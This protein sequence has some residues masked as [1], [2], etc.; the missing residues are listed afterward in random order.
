MNKPPIQIEVIAVSYQKFGELKTFV[1]SWLNQTSRNWKLKVIH[2]GPNRE[3]IK[4]MSAYQLEAPDQITFFCT[5]SRY[6][7][8]GHS[9]RDIALK[10]ATGDYALLT[11][12]DNYFIPKTIEFLIEEI[13]QKDP[14]VVLFDMVHSHNEPGGRDLPPYS[15]FQTSYKRRSIDVSSG[16]VRTSLAQKAGF[17]GRSFDA[18]ALYFEDIKKLKPFFNLRVTKI[19][20]IL[21]VHN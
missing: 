17:R 8:Y 21:F 6:N 7:D 16:I 3:F 18:D 13:V 9:L 2:D 1:Q 5:E 4:I 11:N 19:P 10:E 12:A 20:R 14:D 15:F